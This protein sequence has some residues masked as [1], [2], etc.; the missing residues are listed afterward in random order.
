M[1]R[2]IWV[3]HFIKIRIERYFIYQERIEI[4]V[5]IV[6]ILKKIQFIIYGDETMDVLLKIAVKKN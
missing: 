3:G 1:S 6:Q 4:V 5:I 2:D